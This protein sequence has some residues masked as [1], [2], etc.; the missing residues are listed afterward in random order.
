MI[1]EMGMTLPTSS[2]KHHVNTATVSATTGST[3]VRMTRVTC[4]EDVAGADLN[5]AND[6]SGPDSVGEL[7]L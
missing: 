4:V 3:L 6:L 1:D 5:D 7:V 2:N